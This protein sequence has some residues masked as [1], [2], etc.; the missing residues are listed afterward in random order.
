MR[1]AFLLIWGVVGCSDAKMA[2]NGSDEA[3]MDSVEMDT[4]L[5]MES[6]A[7]EVEDPAHW[8]M[9]GTLLVNEGDIQSELS[10]LHV[11]IVG[12]AGSTLCADNIGI[13]MASRMMEVPEAG[14][15]V[16]WRVVRTEPDPTSCLAQEYPMPLPKPVFVGLG[17]MHPEIE[18]VLAGDTDGSHA[19]DARLRSVYASMRQDSD[20]WVFGVAETTSEEEV[21]IDPA[22]GG[23]SVDGN[24]KFQAVYSFPLTD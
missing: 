13:A 10:F 7:E 8:R 16:W 3:S 22:T 21:G 23:I 6:G 2:M 20:V 17:A 18:A 24:W 4:G 14:V 1:V 9:S 11:A 19:D 12:D 5:D 15:Q